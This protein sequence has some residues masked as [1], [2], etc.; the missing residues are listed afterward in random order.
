MHRSHH[1]G[2]KCS[3]LAI[4]AMLVPLGSHALAQQVDAVPAQ[5]AAA[6]DTPSQFLRVSDDNDSVSLEIAVTDYQSPDGGPIVS[7]VGV[8]HISDPG[9]YELLQDQLDGFRHRSV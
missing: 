5:D 9:Y 6:T 2:P 8:A 7:L 1:S 3:V 4:A